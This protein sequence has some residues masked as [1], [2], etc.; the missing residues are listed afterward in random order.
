MQNIFQTCSF[1]LVIQWRID[2]YKSTLVL[3]RLYSM[4]QNLVEYKIAFIFLLMQLIVAQMCL[5]VL[6][7]RM[8]TQTILIMACMSLFHIGIWRQLPE[9]FVWSNR[10]IICPLKLEKV[11]KPRLNVFYHLVSWTISTFFYFSKKKWTFIR[12]SP[13][14]KLNFL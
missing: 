10:R 4:S 8:C 9:S 3:L 13:Q 6:I 14:V 1:F 11:A 7:S 12:I 5:M 2:Q